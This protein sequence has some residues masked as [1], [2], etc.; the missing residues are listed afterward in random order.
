MRIRDGKIFKLIS[1]M[2]LILLAF[3]SSS[4]QYFVFVEGQQKALPSSQ[5]ESPTALSRASPPPAS[6]KGK[7]P[8]IINNTSNLKVELVFKGIRYPSNMVLLGPN[9]ILVLEKNNGTVKR[10]ANGTMLE[11]PLFDVNVATK[12]E[13]GMLGI[14]VSKHDGSTRPTYVFLYFTES[15]S[16]DGDDLQGK[17][18]LGNRL[19]R[20]ELENNRLIK[21]KL[22]L[23]LPAIPGPHH[24]GGNVLI[25]PDNNLYVVIGDVETHRTQS[26]N[27]AE[28]PID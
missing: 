2:V 17:N 4:S 1:L 22:L 19:Y 13:R 16:K 12:D 25:G 7:V 26:Q 10:I 15:K 20:Y 3:V 14:A 18:P 24:N 27:I 28:G 6:P 9:D 8:T 21:G 23:D 5:P 11:E